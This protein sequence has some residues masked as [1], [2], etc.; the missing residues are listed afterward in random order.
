MVIRK[1]SRKP[2]YYE[3]FCDLLVQQFF[4]L[5]WFGLFSLLCLYVYCDK[6]MQPIAPRSWKFFMLSLVIDS[7]KLVHLCCFNLSCCSYLCL[8]LL[9]KR[10]CRT[11]FSLF[12]FLLAWS[13]LKLGKKVMMVWT[14]SNHWCCSK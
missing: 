1:L 9:H 11:A 2:V 12:Q 6:S 10:C 13:V 14:R 3:H 7:F 4:V 5:C 8:A